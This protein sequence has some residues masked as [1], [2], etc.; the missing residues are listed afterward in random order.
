MGLSKPPANGFVPLRTGFFELMLP[1]ESLKLINVSM[2][3]RVM[4]LSSTLLPIGWTASL[5][6]APVIM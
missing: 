2:R 3:N 1:T 4:A 5:L 6:S